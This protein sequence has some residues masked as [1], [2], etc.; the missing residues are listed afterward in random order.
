MPAAVNTDRE[1]ATNEDR[2][3]DEDA[4]ET[5]DEGLHALSEVVEDEDADDELADAEP[6]DVEE[7]EE[8]E[9]A[10]DIEDLEEALDVVLAARL[11]TERPD[12]DFEDV[13]DDDPGPDG[14]ADVVPL[15]R[16]DE[17]LCRACFL[18]KKTTQLADP[19]AQLCRDCA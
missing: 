15:R 13:E 9:E 14:S 18:L 10:E 12:D 16:R 3:S 6:E 11:Q 2:F 5:A 1:D 17:F 8:A 4:D 7:A 19:S